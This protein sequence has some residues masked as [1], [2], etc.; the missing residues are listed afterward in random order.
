MPYS[1]ILHL[2]NIAAEQHGCLLVSDTFCF[3]SNYPA[4]MY[5]Q[6]EE[7]ALWEN[8][9]CSLFKVKMVVYM[10]LNHA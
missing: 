6:A 7:A 8:L 1:A 2:T 3:A 9:I 5:G 10:N 4:V